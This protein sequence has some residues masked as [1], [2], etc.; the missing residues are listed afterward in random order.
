MQKKGFEYSIK[1]KKDS[2]SQPQQFGSYG[3]EF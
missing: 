2:R 3:I 1:D